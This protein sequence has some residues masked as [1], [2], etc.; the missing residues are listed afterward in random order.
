MFGSGDEICYRQTHTHTRIQ[1]RLKKKRAKSRK[2]SSKILCKSCL[3][4]PKNLPRQ[5]ILIRDDLDGKWCVR[6][7]TSSEY[8]ASLRLFDRCI[9]V[10]YAEWNLHFNTLK[11]VQSII[12]IFRGKIHSFG[13]RIK[14]KFRFI[15]KSKRPSFK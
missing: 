13:H 7:Y 2:R 1:A 11:L 12:V 10:C 9:D 8:Q 3:N 5:R 6:Y 15:E 4:E 14:W